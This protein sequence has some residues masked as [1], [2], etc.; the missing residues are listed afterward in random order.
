MKGISLYIFCLFLIAEACTPKNIKFSDEEKDLFLKSAQT[1]NDQITS[2]K[3]TLLHCPLDSIET[4]SRIINGCSYKTIN[5]SSKRKL[6]SLLS[7]QTAKPHVLIDKEYISPGFLQA[8]D[9]LAF[10]ALSKAKWRSQ[11]SV[12][13]FVEYILPYK[14]EV[15]FVDNWRELL[16]SHYIDLVSADSSLCNLDSLY[17]YHKRHTYSSLS[18]HL[19]IKNQYP[20]QDNFSW[21]SFCNEGDCVARCLLMMYHLRAAGAPATLDYIPAWGNRPYAKH[22]YVGLANRAE[23]VEKLLEN[24]NDPHNAVNDLNGCMTDTFMFIFP[25]HEIPKGIYVQYEKT[26][27]KVYRKTWSVQKDIVKILDRHSEAEI[28]RDLLRPNSI[29]V[30]NQY[31]K[32]VDVELQVD[33]AANKS[34][35]Y[36]AVFDTNGWRPVSYAVVKDKKAIFKNMGKNI[37]YIPV[38]EMGR[39]PE[40][41]GSPFVLTNEGN[42]CF[43]EPDY[44]NRINMSLLRKYPL[45]AYSANYTKPFKNAVITG[46][47]D[48]E[49]RLSEDIYKIQEYPFLPLTINVNT[50]EEYEWIRL[51][52][53]KNEKARVNT[54]DCYTLNS[55]GEEK[56]IEGK[57]IRV[58]GQLQVNFEE[59]T[60][61]SKI[62][63][64]PRNDEN[65]IIKGNVYELMYWDKGWNSLGVKEAQEF[66][67]L[68]DNVPANALYWLKCLTEGKEERIFTYENGKQIW[69]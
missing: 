12:G 40:P 9:S 62:V 19:D 58:D 11:V 10:L 4:I 13:D 3:V 48:S 20:S 64:W 23:Q 66:S 15:E 43:L 59:A 6:N 61:V 51:Q 32:T 27:P 67:L 68:F 37:V 36:L 65:F 1:I 30:T 26:I 63:I 57:I 22:A 56:K 34:L 39:G 52:T 44:N 50:N 16:F 21:L 46:G 17:L 8:Q 2:A 47:V 5:D 54:F 60:T 53:E 55:L 33:S 24:S 41:I 7:N 45:F 69:W 42:T 25:T 35:V 18:K 31:L 14:Q 29:D 38:C 49:N 28:D